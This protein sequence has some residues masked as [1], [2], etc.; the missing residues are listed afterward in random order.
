[1]QILGSYDNNQILFIFLLAYVYTQVEDTYCSGGGGTVYTTLADAQD[2]CT[3]NPSCLM[4]YDDNCDDTQFYVCPNNSEQRGSSQGS[5][6]YVKS[7][8]SSGK[9]RRIIVRIALSS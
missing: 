8:T 2:A 6:I 7:S 5:C 3:Q 4:V 1:M 9:I